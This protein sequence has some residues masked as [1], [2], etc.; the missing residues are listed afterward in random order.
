MLRKGQ[1]PKTLLIHP[2]MMRPL[3]PPLKLGSI[4]GIGGVGACGRGGK[5]VRAPRSEQHYRPPAPILTNAVVY[6]DAGRRG[7]AIL[8]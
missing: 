4:A 8:L 2:D 3:L 6:D 5:L 1:A 7:R